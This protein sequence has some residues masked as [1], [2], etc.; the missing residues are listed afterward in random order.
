MGMSSVLLDDESG[1]RGRIQDR[2]VSVELS[3]YRWDIKQKEVTK[4]PLP[5]THLGA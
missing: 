3:R 1:G 4:K 5:A 2:D